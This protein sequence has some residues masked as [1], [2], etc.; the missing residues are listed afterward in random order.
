MCYKNFLYVAQVRIFVVLHFTIHSF[1]PLPHSSIATCYVEFPDNLFFEDRLSRNTEYL[2][3]VHKL[4]RLGR[5]VGVW[6]KM[7]NFL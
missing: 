1:S 5:G 3:A 4:S 2:G 6:Y 7:A